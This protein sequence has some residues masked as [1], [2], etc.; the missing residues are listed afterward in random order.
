[1]LSRTN[2]FSFVPLFL[3]QDKVKIVSSKNIAHL[4]LIINVFVPC[5]LVD[6]NHD[7]GSHSESKNLNLTPQSAHGAPH[8]KTDLREQIMVSRKASADGAEMSGKQ[9]SE[10]LKELIESAAEK[11]ICSSSAACCALKA[12][13]YSLKHIS[14]RK[15]KNAPDLLRRVLSMK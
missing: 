3:D 14:Q 5:S 9:D 11:A 10:F 13:A 12:S 2:D 4:Q 8:F 1:M 6:W 7:D 15:I